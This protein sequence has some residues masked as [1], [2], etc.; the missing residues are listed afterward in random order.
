MIFNRSNCKVIVKQK[1]NTQNKNKMWSISCVQK[2]IHKELIANVQSHH[3]EINHLVKLNILS[4]VS[5]FPSKAVSYPD[6]PPCLFTVCYCDTLL[7]S[8]AFWPFILTKHCIVC[9]QYEEYLS[10]IANVTYTT[11]TLD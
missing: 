1:L 11:N 10:Y 2:F 7:L 8:G 9:M 4:T 5:W 6:H 3:N